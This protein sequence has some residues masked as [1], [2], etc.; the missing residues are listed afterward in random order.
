MLETCG[1]IGVV[2]ENKASTLGYGLIHHHPSVD[3]AIHQ[4][5]RS[6]VSRGTIHL[7]E[8]GLAVIISPFECISA[9]YEVARPG[10][11]LQW[12]P[13]K[14]PSKLDPLTPPKKKKRKRKKKE[15]RAR[16]PSFLSALVTPFSKQ[17][18]IICSTPSTRDSNFHSAVI[19]IPQTLTRA[20]TTLRQSGHSSTRCAQSKQ[21]TQCP[22]LSKT[23]FNG[24]S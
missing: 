23:V 2:S 20:L 14:D 10:Y 4:K 13:P 9:I 3:Q 22:Q 12:P 17:S 8:R 7:K 1:I 18:A 15:K 16:T 11:L 5:A 24:S 21:V 6:F 19:L